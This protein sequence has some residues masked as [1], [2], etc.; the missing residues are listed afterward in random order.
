MK[1]HSHCHAGQEPCTLLLNR[2]DVCS[3]EHF[4]PK[5]AVDRKT[6]GDFLRPYIRSLGRLDQRISCSDTD[7]RCWTIRACTK[8]TQPSQSWI[9][10]V[11]LLDT[12]QCLHWFELAQRQGKTAESK[13][14]SPMAFTAFCFFPPIASKIEESWGNECH[15]NECSKVF[16]NNCVITRKQLKKK[17]Q[18]GFWCGAHFLTVLS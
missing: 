5:S 3:S 14:S 6:F 16:G 11:P 9:P 12:P 10:E 8:I 17:R 2:A 13:T 18:W 15:K 1:L 7:I 4:S